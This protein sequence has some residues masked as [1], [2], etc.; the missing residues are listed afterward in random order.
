MV[1]VKYCF[2][3]P[4]DGRSEYVRKTLKGT[5]SQLV[6]CSIQRNVG[7]WLLG[8]HSLMVRALAA[9]GRHAEAASL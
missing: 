8:G 1:H 9:Q 5:M 4:A 3:L 7:L 6:T 2:L